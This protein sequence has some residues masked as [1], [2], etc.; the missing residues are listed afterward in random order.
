MHRLNGGQVLVHH[1]VQ[2]AAALL[3]IAY[4]A[5]QNAHIGI[6]IHKHFHIHHIAQLLAGKNQDAF[7][8]DD[9]GRVYRN[10]LIAAVVDRVIIYRNLHAFAAAQSLQVLHQQ[11][12]IKGSGWS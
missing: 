3:N 5:A 12:G 6:G 9:R 10:G 11:L 4:N 8:N 1:A 7:H 2:R